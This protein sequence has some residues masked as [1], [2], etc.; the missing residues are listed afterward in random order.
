MTGSETTLDMW[1]KTELPIHL[2]YRFHI[3]DDK[4]NSKR[5][6]RDFNSVQ[7]E[8]CK[9]ANQAYKTAMLKIGCSKPYLN[10]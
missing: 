1:Q 3:I 4:G 5:I 7:E 2:Q 6:S 9:T 8:F 10:Q